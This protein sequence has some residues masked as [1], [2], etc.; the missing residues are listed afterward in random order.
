MHAGL[1]LQPAFD[2]AKARESRCDS[3]G[4]HIERGRSGTRRQR[5]R[6][7]M[8]SRRRYYG[9]CRAKRGGEHDFAVELS[10]LISSS[11]RSLAFHREFDLLLVPPHLAP[12]WSVAV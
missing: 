9:A 4:G 10:R 1:A 7:V 8:T 2:S 3:R 5:V 12:S 6:D 11:H